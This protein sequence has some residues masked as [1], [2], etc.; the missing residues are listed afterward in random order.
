MRQAKPFREAEEHTMK[1]TLFLLIVG[2]I[3]VF[4]STVEA[5][6]IT[7]PWATTYNCPEQQQGISLWATCDGISSFGNWTAN[8]QSEQITRL[9]NK[10]DGAGGHGH[11]QWTSERTS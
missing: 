11:R 4:C 6:T 2:V 1:K 7:L 3:V 5:Q 10:P 9:A 8:G